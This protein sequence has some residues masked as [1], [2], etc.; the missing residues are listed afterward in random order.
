[1]N[2]GL[3]K[4]SRPMKLV[5][6]WLLKKPDWL[7]HWKLPLYTYRLS[8][9]RGLNSCGKP[10]NLWPPSG[11]RIRYSKL[12]KLGKQAMVANMP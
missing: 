8:K 9:P 12:G 1:M 10:E 4:S 11:V 6:P 7:S 5:M 3:T 2:T